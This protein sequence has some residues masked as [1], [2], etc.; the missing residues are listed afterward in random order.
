MATK[1]RRRAFG[2]VRLSKDTPDTTSPARQREAIERLCADRRWELVH[3][4]EDIDVSAYNGRHRPQFDNMMRRLHEIDAI[5][6]WR[7]DRLSRNVREGGEIAERC[8]A[9]EV[10]L[11]AV[12]DGQD[13][14]D[15]TSADG[16]FQFNL[17]MGLGQREV[18]LL[19]ERTKAGVD[20]AREQGAYLGGKRYGWRWSDKRLVPDRRQQ[21]V[22]RKAAKRYIAGDSFNSIARELSEE[23]VASLPKTRMDGSPSTHKHP[24]QSRRLYTHAL[25]RMLQDA[26]VHDALGDLGD[27]LA[28]AVAA[29]KGPGRA[30]PTVSLLGGV[31]SCA[32]CG[33]SLRLSS[34][35]AGRGGRW[36]QYR[37]TQTGHAGIA[38]TFLEEYVSE[39][40]LDA[41]DIPTLTRRMKAR[42]RRPPKAAEV[43]AIEARLQN[44]EDSFGDGTLSKA[45]FIR[46][47]DRQLTKLEAARQATVEEQVPELSLEL[48]RHLPE[49]W[50][51]MTTIGKREVIRA[52]LREVRVA[53]AS[54]HGKIEPSRVELVWRT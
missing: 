28:R 6:F 27:E 47:R 19:S 23:Y 9:A 11:V 48:A 14:I 16:E 40:V 12:A 43:V 36:R 53:K 37:C 34:T 7:L 25:S 20:K 21:A 39:A 22:L 54:G 31:A 51:T 2:Y 50:P 41:I 33:G 44:L 24:E 17:M 3:T 10:D 45:A 38:A 18:R 52:L 30:R 13:R 49:R 46:Q 42:L 15:T 29:R 32:M 35:A 4:F 1:V 26:R 5:V 8:K